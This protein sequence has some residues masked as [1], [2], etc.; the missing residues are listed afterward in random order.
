[1]DVTLLL[2]VLAYNRNIETTPWVINHYIT[3]W[4]RGLAIG[5]QVKVERSLLDQ[6]KTAPLHWELQGSSH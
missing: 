5:T 4:N 3:Q 6:I 1:M 2:A